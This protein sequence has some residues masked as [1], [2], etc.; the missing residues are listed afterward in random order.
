MPKRPQTRGKRKQ[1][2]RR[3]QRGGADLPPEL[4]GMKFPEK[5]ALTI[6]DGTAPPTNSL[7]PI[8]AAK[9]EPTVNWSEPTPGNFRTL[10]CFDPDAAANSWLHWLVANCTRD[11]PLSG[12]TFMPWAPPTPPSGIHRYYFALFEHAARIPVEATPKE[13]GYF[14]VKQ[15]I[16]EYGLEPVA[17]AMFRVKSSL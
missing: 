9:S 1:T 4:A 16:K 5:L 14:G 2:R 12:S 3:G 7:V 11:T 10:I 15:F 13:R 6:S 17:F 8:Q